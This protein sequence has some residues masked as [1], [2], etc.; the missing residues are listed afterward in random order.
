MAQ[1]DQTVQNATFP[2]VRADINSNLAALFSNS[3]GNGAPSVTVAFQDWIDT[4]GT[5]AVWKKRN[6]ANSAWLT[7]ATFLGSGLTLGG[8]APGTVM[9]FVQTSAPTGWTKNT[10]HDNKAL[11]IVS[12]AAGTGGSTAFT[13]V[14]TSRA[15][16]GSVAAT[17]LTEAQMPSHA[18]PYA[19]TT[20]TA[21]SVYPGN[22]RPNS[23]VINTGAAG[24][25]ASH[26]HGF[27][28]SAMDFA[29]Q[30]VDVIIA[31]KD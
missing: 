5:D 22:V 27:A 30:Y 10:A 28:G 3:S 23:G 31:T 2:T 12:G 15:T 29:V 26:T 1:A 17:T 11:R 21:G 8:F 9:L 13:T 4:S 14:F 16:S 24:G 20:A 25:G 18:H 19:S 6:G 7:V